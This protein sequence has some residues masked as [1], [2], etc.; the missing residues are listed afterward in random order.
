MFA[1]LG[2]SS[3]LFSS[4]LVAWELYINQVRNRMQEVQD[5]VSYP[6]ERQMCEEISKPDYIP[7]PRH[8]LDNINQFE[9]MK[10]S[11]AETKEEG[12]AG[13]AASLRSARKGWPSS[14][15][16]WTGGT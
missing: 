5:N 16:W 11:P 6:S 9:E 3:V 14:L 13:G 1:A 10:L 15:V 7:V 4:G 12:L 2:T 8:I